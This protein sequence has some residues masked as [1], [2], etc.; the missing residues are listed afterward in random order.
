MAPARV[1]CRRRSAAGG[2]RT[3]APRPRPDRTRRAR[4]PARPAKAGTICGPRGC[5]KSGNYG[6]SLHGGITVTVDYG[7]SLLEFSQQRQLP[8]GV[9]VHRGFGPGLPGAR[10]R[11]SCRSSAAIH[12]GA[13]SGRP[14]VGARSIRAVVAG[15]AGAVRS[16]A[17]SGS[18]RVMAPPSPV[19]HPRP[20]DGRE[21]LT[22]A[23]P[24]HGSRAPR[25]PD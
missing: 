3:A 14:I 8:L 25:P 20:R 10:R 11:P 21:R 18:A 12:S 17:K 5:A 19:R 16:A 2:P 4:P 13:P 24:R 6:D 23:S 7:D 22:M 9:P 15:S 1:W